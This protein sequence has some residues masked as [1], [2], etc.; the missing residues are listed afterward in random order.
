MLLEIHCHSAEHSRCSV[1]PAAELVRQALERGVQ[2][3]VLTD[4]HYRWEDEELAALR[5]DAGVPAHFLL[6]SGQEVSTPD[7]GHVV[8]YGSG[9]SLPEGTTSSEIRERLPRAALVRA[10]P[11]RTR[12]D[13]DPRR[14]LAPQ[15]DAVE[16]F[17][18][19]HTMLANSR[20][21][22]AWHRLRFTATAGTDAHGQIPAGTFPTLFDH[23]VSDVDELAREIRAGRC[24]PLL[25][26]I[27]LAGANTVVTE[28]VIG[29][30]GPAGERP[31]LIVR[32]MARRRD[33]R[34]GLRTA[35]LMDELAARGFAAGP[36]RLPQVLERDPAR[37]T[38][39]EEGVRGR[40][41]FEVLRSAGPD[42]GRRYLELAAGWLARL[43]AQSLEPPAPPE[44][45]DRERRR[46][47]GYGERFE[48]AGDPRA[49]LVRALAAAILERELRLPARERVQSHGD[50][51]PKNLIVGQDSAENRDTVYVAAVDL[52]SA[53]SAPRAFDVGWFLAHYRHQFLDDRRVLERWPAEIF[54]EAYRREAGAPAAAFDDE[55]A[56]FAARA[57]LSIAAYLLKLGL[58]GHETVRRLL[59]GATRALDLP[60]DPAGVAAAGGAP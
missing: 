13:L 56:L 54:L 12:P 4:H 26:E 20:A 51:H 40:P 47:A 18:A 57:D 38:I 24:R 19:N 7:L 34:R 2:G 33:W 9:P 29:A 23:P 39:I 36:Y 16:I 41:L 53:A 31:R 30:K 27:T 37:M 22:D 55:V 49:A 58:G 32:R 1:A 25:K 21:L 43:H 3:L 46:L 14:L 52:A 60:G 42:E 48:R 6:L 5:R 17:S 11:L 44:F 35:V 10:H 59:A 50:F 8:V 15:L 28:I 45:T